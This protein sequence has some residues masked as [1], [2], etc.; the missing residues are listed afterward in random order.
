MTQKSERIVIWGAGYIGLTTAIA[1]AEKGQKSM[2]YDININ[3]INQVKRGDIIIEN[4]EVWCGY[5]FRC[6]FRNG[7]IKVS[8]FNGQLYSNIHFLAVPTEKNM[9][10][11]HDA[12]VDVIIKITNNTKDKN[13][14]PVIIVESTLTPGTTD[15]VI[16]PLLKKKLYNRFHLAIAPRRDWFVSADKNLKT[17][18]RVVGSVNKTDVNVISSLLRTICSNIVLANDYHSAE[19]VKSIENVLRYVD[20]TVANQLAFAYPNLDIVEILN[21][22]GTKWNINTYTPGF[23]IGGYCIPLSA[24]YVMRGTTLEKELSVVNAAK[25]FNRQYAQKIID[26][27]HLDQFQTIGILGL[28]YKGD[29]KVYKGSPTLNIIESMDHKKI[30]VHDPY[31]LEQEIWDIT[32]C[33]T[34]SFPEDLARFDCLLLVTDH[35]KYSSI[36]KENL[37]S[38]INSYTSIFDGTGI[39][40]NYFNENDHIDYRQIGWSHWYRE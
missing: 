30:C 23:G 29:I 6:W 28:S 10:P 40:K 1:Y 38:K 24:E 31:F 39:W 7:M 36:C 5:D 33:N 2:I 22:A 27:L 37:L 21:L 8:L 3:K 17:L 25:E 35:K 14:Y 16:L 32:G 18:P 13:S 15:K 34:F 9:V 12:I 26:V 11:D 4:L 19:A 20:I